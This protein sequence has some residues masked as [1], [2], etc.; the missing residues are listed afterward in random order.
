MLVAKATAL[1]MLA[2]L[3]SVEHEIHNL[4]NPLEAFE[5]DTKMALKRVNVDIAALASRIEILKVAE[6]QQR[7]A[8]EICETRSKREEDRLKSAQSPKEVQG[9]QRELKKI[10][11]LLAES[12]R[13][14]AS[15]QV[16]LEDF[17]QTMYHLESARAKFQGQLEKPE[18]KQLEIDSSQL[19]RLRKRRGELEALMSQAH[20]RL[21]RRI[22]Q[23]RDGVAAVPLQGDKCGGCFV[24]LPPQFVRDMMKTPEVEC[25]PNCR[26][27]LLGSE[28]SDA[29]SI[30]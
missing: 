28:Q 19:E 26:R 18:S 13:R 2:E 6:R 8:T 25:C 14:Q 9:I 20:L 29:V 5:R 23:L 1:K 15:L 7:G 3:Q 22:A 17:T 11:D 16:Q 30:G 10:S 21:F 12:R 27:I 24:V 4:Q